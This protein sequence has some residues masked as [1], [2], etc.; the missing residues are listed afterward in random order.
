[1]SVRPRSPR[2]AAARWWI[3]GVSFPQFHVMVQRLAHHVLLPRQDQQVVLDL[4]RHAQAQPELREPLPRSGASAP[5]SVAP[6][7]TV[8]AMNDAVFEFHDPEV[9]RLVQRQ[10]SRGGER[11]Q[12]AAAQRYPCLA[13]EQRGVLAVA[14]RA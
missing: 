10:G 5:E 14:R 13:D 7:G 11:E 8:T 9:R 2:P 4:E 1:M 12:F 3:T 6:A